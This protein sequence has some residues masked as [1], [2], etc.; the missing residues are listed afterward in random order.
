[1]SI[2]I[3]NKL[4]SEKKFKEALEHLNLL[5]TTY[6]NTLLERTIKY[7]TRYCERKLIRQLY[8]KDTCYN[9]IIPDNNNESAKHISIKNRKKS[10]KEIILFC[11]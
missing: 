6:K 2:A 3:A 7:N 10:G 5:A 8:L 4:L 9:K 1:M 11:C